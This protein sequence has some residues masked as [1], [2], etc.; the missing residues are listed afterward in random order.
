MKKLQAPQAPDSVVCIHTADNRL[1]YVRSSAVTSAGFVKEKT[2]KGFRWALV[3]NYA[4]PFYTKI[5]DMAEALQV[6]KEFYGQDG[7]EEARSVVG[8]TLK[9]I[10]GFR[11]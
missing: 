10:T 7:L 11:P 5:I 8:E 9:N 4:S 2:D 6:I 1:D 3:L